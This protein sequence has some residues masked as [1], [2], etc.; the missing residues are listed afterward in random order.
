MALVAEADANAFEI[1]LERHGDAAFALAYRI[2]GRRNF[3]EDV[4]QEAFLSIWR[5]GGRYDRTRA[6]VRTWTLGIVHNRAIDMLRRQAPHDSRRAS[7][8]GISEWLAAPGRTDEE[9]E[10]RTVAR[11]V[12]E[13]ISL[14][15]A[16]QAQV[17]ELAYFGGFTHTEIAAMLELPVGT[18]KGRMRLGLDKLRTI[19]APEHAT[20]VRSAR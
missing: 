9:V 11:E 6:S 18:V 15:P 16:E 12:R 5:A 20:E 3:A 17:I 7:D 10:R 19:I 14:L 13:A 2:L 1:I 4:V 8:E